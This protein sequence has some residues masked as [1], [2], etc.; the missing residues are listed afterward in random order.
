MDRKKKRE[1][2]RD[3]ETLKSER[4]KRILKNNAKIFYLSPDFIYL[5]SLR[6][7]KKYFVSNKKLSINFVRKRTLN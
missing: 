3:K 6:L 4:N 7:I 5:S 1:S 2:E